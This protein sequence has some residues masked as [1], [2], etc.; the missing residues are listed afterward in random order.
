MRKK[1]K[2]TI[3]RAKMAIGLLTLVGIVSFFIMSISANE[4]ATMT[5]ITVDSV[6]LMR[7]SP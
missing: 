1:A 3:T 4:K 2:L 5:K 7:K 6:L